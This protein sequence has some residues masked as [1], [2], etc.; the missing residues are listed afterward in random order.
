MTDQ[1]PLLEK[2]DITFDPEEALEYYLELEKNYQEYRWNYSDYNPDASSKSYYGKMY[3][4]SMNSNT[5][6]NNAPNRDW[7]GDNFRETPCAFGFAKKVMNFFK[8]ANY[9]CVTVVPP[10]THLSLHVDDA[11]FKR[12]HL[13]L[14][15]HEKF[16]FY[17]QHRQ[18]HTTEPGNVY[19]LHTERFHGAKHQGI[20][21]RAH[22]M[23]K[24]E[25]N[26][27]NSIYSK[28][29]SKI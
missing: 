27:I 3:G 6:L 9:V 12:I 2:L 16:Y 17:D 18:K 13:P 21:F 4:W 5:D 14:T 1:L 20:D 29:G 24:Y 19:I 26:L 8:D 22:L 28:H 25:T 11:R 23:V 15:K 7:N 10:D